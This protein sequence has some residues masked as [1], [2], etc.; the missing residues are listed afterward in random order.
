MGWH[1]YDQDQ[2]EIQFAEPSWDVTS[3]A[4]KFLARRKVNTYLEKIFEINIKLLT[5][6]NITLR[7]HATATMLQIKK[8][9]ESKQWAPISKQRLFQNWVELSNDQL[10][11]DVYFQGNHLWLFPIL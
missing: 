4:E 10:V 1:L 6:T 9:L 3:F 7:M 2:I 8:R 11:R 5:G